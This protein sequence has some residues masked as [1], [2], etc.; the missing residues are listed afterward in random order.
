[1][2]TVKAREY[3]VS[4][5]TEGDNLYQGVKV[6]IN[7]EMIADMNRKVRIDLCDDPLYKALWM[8]VKNNPPKKEDMIDG[9]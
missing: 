6:T 8:Y 7:T 4:F 9:N 1:M 5:N 3:F 2:T